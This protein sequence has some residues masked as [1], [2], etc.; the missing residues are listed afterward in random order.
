MSTRDKSKGGGPVSSLRRVFATAVVVALSALAVVVGAAGAF[1]PTAEQSG[2]RDVHARS[3]VPRNGRIVFQRFDPGL[4]KFR[5]YTIRP[6]GTGLRAIT[7]PPANA[8]NDMLPDWSPDG[9]KIVFRRDFAERSMLI[10]VNP[11]GS[12]PRNLTRRSCTG[13]CLGDDE[14]EWSPDGRRIAF[15]RAI[16]PIPPDGPPPVV[17]IFVMD[18]DGSNVRQLT[19][20]VPNSGTEDHSPSWSPD[21][22]RIAF[23]RANNTRPPE[24]QSFIFT[25][26][27][28]GGR[29]T[30]VRRMPRRWPG[31]GVPEWSPDGR[32]ILFSTYCAFGFCGQPLTG[33][34]LF[35]IRPNGEDLRQLTHLPGNS[36]DGSYSPDG[37]KIVFAR[38]PRVAPLGDLYIM[39]RDGTH[40]R[41][42]T[43]A[44]RRDNH[45]PDWGPFRGR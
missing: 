17:G 44:L 11:D 26:D 20:P 22:E 24:N 23:M 37:R 45:N 7:K 31:A 19:Q 32:R 1:M 28:D 4:G 41:R 25:V 3:D 39:R 8:F 12:N 6:D 38:N 29:P 21:G 36:Y 2:E 43:H 5:I 18:A 15:G 27:S 10:V 35:T 16:G 14:P 30:L 34:Q 40:V 42:L 9:S 13:D 33:A